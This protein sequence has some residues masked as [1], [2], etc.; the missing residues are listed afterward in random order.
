MP[1][2]T[3]FLHFYSI[4]D[5]GR[6]AEV[7]AGGLQPAEAARPLEVGDGGHAGQARQ[8]DAVEVKLSF[9]RHRQKRPNMQIVCP[10][11][12]FQPGACT[13]KLFYNHNLRIFII[14]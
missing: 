5:V 1:E 14:S 2:M 12:P 9:L 13:K 7:A 4:E 6:E 11:Q 8:R 10:W 3:V